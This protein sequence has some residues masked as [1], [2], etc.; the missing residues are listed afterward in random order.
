MERRKKMMKLVLAVLLV[1]SNAAAAGVFEKSWEAN[2]DGGWNLKRVLPL[3]DGY[4]V[5]DGRLKKVDFQGNVENWGPSVQDVLTVHYAVDG[6]FVVLNRVRA[7]GF[8]M[9]K[10]NEDGSNQW[11]VVHLPEEGFF[12]CSNMIASFDRKYVMVGYE[13]PSGNRPQSSLIVMKTDA[14]GRVLWIFRFA[15]NLINRG[16]G[17]HEHLDGG[18]LVTGVTSRS[19]QSFGE[20]LLVKID[21]NGNLLWW[22][23]LPDGGSLELTSQGEILIISEMFRRLSFQG[24]ILFERRLPV[25][26]APESGIVSTQAADGNFLISGSS[27]SVGGN[28]IFVVK[29]NEKG[30]IFWQASLKD[31]G[32]QQ[33]FGLRWIGGNDYLLFGVTS[34]DPVCVV[35]PSVFLALFYIADQLQFFSQED[36]SW[37]VV[38]DVETQFFPEYPTAVIIHGFNPDVS[39]REMPEWSARLSEAIRRRIEGG[40]INIL[41]WNWMRE[42]YAPSLFEIGGPL[43]NVP[44]QANLLAF[45]LERLFQEGQYP[46]DG[47]L[48]IFGHSLGAFLAVLAADT[49]GRMGWHTPHQVTLFDIADRAR[50]TGVSVATESINGMISRLRRDHQTYFDLYHGITSEGDHGVD[51]WVNVPGVSHTENL[52]E[53]YRN[54]VLDSLHPLLFVTT[55]WWQR[56]PINGTLGFDLSPL[57]AMDRPENV[58]SINQLETQF[59]ARPVALRGEFFWR[60]NEFLRIG[61]KC[62]DDPSP[63]S[64]GL[65]S[66]A[67]VEPSDTGSIERISDSHVRLISGS[68]AGFTLTL[69]INERWDYFSFWYRFVG[70]ER[71]SQLSV[72]VYYPQN[73]TQ[74]LIFMMPEYAGTPFDWMTTGLLDVSS[75]QGEEI[76]LLFKWYSAAQGASVEI[77]DLTFWTDA[78]HDNSPPKADAGMD[79]S[80]VADAE[81]LSL[82]R[83]DGSR[84]VDEDASDLTFWWMIDGEF[85]D[86]GEVTEVELPLGSYEITLV[87]RD[88]FDAISMDVLLVEVEFPFLRGDANL[89]RNLNLSDAVF[90]L[91]FLFL[92]GDLLPCFDSADAND[93]SV[94]D[95]ADAVFILNY[96]FRGGN[97]I[98]P[99]NDE[100][101]VDPTPDSLGCRGFGR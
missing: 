95:L 83:L 99:P 51:I 13:Q 31:D 86:S 14:D 1:V 12:I 65:I 74:E 77:K 38:D 50:Y 30:E 34:R 24:E 56:E 75:I 3:A 58:C 80:Y 5:A 97:P 81:G 23:T 66:L 21:Q 84:T 19:A 26:L 57:S 44:Y 9:M 46:P 88:E 87:V 27:R 48:H 78:G 67:D 101:G 47:I 59:Y 10:V 61:R 2:I 39:R 11:S 33:V 69:Q 94:V 98:P 100:Q 89:D 28:D 37:K 91:N 20:F 79:R 70:V 16:F 53:W 8:E 92:S 35:R 52:H 64:N 90:V 15:E 29:V 85:L 60:E 18:Y 96:L 49:L 17:I 76:Q 40:R 7:R 43:R 32:C 42:A 25:S 62:G 93:D 45:Q 82:I 71:F 73:D 4:L 55:G 36:G 22:R 72:F 63:E 6:G 54:T 68:T 41:G